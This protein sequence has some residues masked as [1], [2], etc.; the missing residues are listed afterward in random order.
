MNDKK[1]SYDAMK[2][3]EQHEKKYEEIFTIAKG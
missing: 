1:K 3:W 2:N